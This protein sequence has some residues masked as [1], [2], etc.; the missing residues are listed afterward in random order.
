MS[1]ILIHV[2]TDAAPT[3][4]ADVL[5][6]GFVDAQAPQPSTRRQNP[7]RLDKDRSPFSDTKTNLLFLLFDLG[8]NAK[9]VSVSYSRADRPKI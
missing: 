9:G 3:S 2:R 7:R 4:P 1:A 6:E 8:V 5:G